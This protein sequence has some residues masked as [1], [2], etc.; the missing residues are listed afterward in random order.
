MKTLARNHNDIVATWR[1]IPVSK[2]LVIPIYRPCRPFGRGPTLLS[3]LT[4]HG[5]SPLTDW[6]DPPRSCKV[7]PYQL[8]VGSH[9]NFTYGGDFTPVKPI[10]FRPF[11]G[12]N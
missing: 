3:G 9:N 11:I 1:I 2:W 4:K 6:D 5:Y 8:Y 12:V 10:Y 7:G